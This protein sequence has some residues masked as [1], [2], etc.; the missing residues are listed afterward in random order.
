MDR[1]ENSATGLSLFGEQ[2]DL[3][4]PLHFFGYQMK[5]EQLPLTHISDFCETDDIV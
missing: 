3:F 2:P 1:N 5:S 4:S